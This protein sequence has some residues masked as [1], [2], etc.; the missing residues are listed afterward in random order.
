MR[1]TTG[2]R[3]KQLVKEKGLEQQEVAAE[4]GM[5]SPTFN[6][7]ISNNREPSITKLKQLAGYFGVSVD[8]LTGYSNIKDPYLKHLPAELSSFVNEPENSIYIELA[9]DI[10]SKTQTPETDRQKS[11]K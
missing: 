7:Y 10:K 1:I 11:V 4:L 2:D 8:Y 9:A 3:L 6:G 5:K